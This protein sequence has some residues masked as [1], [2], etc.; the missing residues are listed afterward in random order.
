MPWKSPQLTRATPGQRARWEEV[1]GGRFIHWPD[2]DEDI[3]LRG[4]LAT[5]AVVAPPDEDLA[6]HPQAGQ[7]S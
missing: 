2:V 4:L 3:D 7:P 5:E 1:T 6:I